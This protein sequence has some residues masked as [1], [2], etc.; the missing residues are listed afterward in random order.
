MCSHVFS[1]LRVYLYPRE[2]QESRERSRA[3]ELKGT[4]V[5]PGVKFARCPKR[6]GPGPGIQ[7]ESESVYQVP[8]SVPG[9]SGEGGRGFGVA[10]PE[11][12]PS[13]VNRVRIC[14]L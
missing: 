13:K 9:N 8:L 7:T 3:N 2:A 14:L 1:C 10:G 11:R 4:E 6:E 5:P 12:A